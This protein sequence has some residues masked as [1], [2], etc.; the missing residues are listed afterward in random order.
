MQVQPQ[1]HNCNIYWQ[2][3]LERKIEEKIWNGGSICMKW[4]IWSLYYFVAILL[5]I[6]CSISDQNVEYTFSL[7]ISFLFNLIPWCLRQIW[8]MNI[9]NDTESKTIFSLF[10]LFYWN[11]K[12]HPLDI[13]KRISIEETWFKTSQPMKRMNLLFNQDV[14]M[15][16]LSFTQALI[17]YGKHA[18]GNL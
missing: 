11:L 12:Y 1:W 3:Q 10:I 13:S 17:K 15:S 9:C 16:V 7:K 14:S 6:K 5:H 8:G 2:M 4:K 18:I